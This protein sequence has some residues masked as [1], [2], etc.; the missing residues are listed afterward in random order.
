MAAVE[1][2]FFALLYARLSVF[3][4]KIISLSYQAKGTEMLSYHLISSL[5]V[6]DYLRE[7]FV[8]VVLHLKFLGCHLI[9]LHLV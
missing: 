9:L 3:L 4:R 1:I 2:D 8:L 6:L 7:F 5:K